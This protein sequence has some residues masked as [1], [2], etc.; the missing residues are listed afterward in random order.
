MDLQSSQKDSAL[1]HKPP[2][3]HLH[4]RTNLSRLTPSG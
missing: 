4:T 2:I 1:G 3:A